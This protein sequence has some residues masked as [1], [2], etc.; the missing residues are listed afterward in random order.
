MLPE[1]ATPPIVLAVDDAAETLCLLTDIL[2]A[3]G[4]TALIARNGAK[5]LS[6]LPQVKPDLILMDAVMPKMDGF[7]TCRRIK[8]ARDFAHIPIIFMTGLSDTEHVVK[9]FESGGVDYVTK[10]IVPDELLARIRVHLANSRL[11]QSARIAL[12]IS[13]TRVIAVNSSGQVLWITPDAA[14]LF[15]KVHEGFGTEDPQWRDEIAPV[16]ARVFAQR[17]GR[18]L[19]CNTPG[20]PLY[21]SF[22]GESRH[23]E[24][25]IRL[26]DDSSSGDEEILRKEFDLTGREAEVLLWITQGKSNRDVA[27]ILECSP[28]T[29]NKHLEQIF[30]KLRVENRT[31]A[32]MIA[33]RALT[34]G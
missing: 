14:K 25:L 26:S 24:H 4:M 21:A 27:A 30:Q 22:I 23:D 1:P 33:I 10:P 15:G 13:G 28:R 5:A 29:V 7:E 2:E 19:L 18:T 32:A 9:G 34:K 11:A 3:A 31:A 8:K 20:G 16:L 12:D 17:L 6:L